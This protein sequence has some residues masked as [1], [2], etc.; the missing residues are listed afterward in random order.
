MKQSPFLICIAAILLL[1]AC[2]PIAQKT[3]GKRYKGKFE[4]AGLCSNYTF[5]NTDGTIDESLVVPLWTNPQTGKIY[6]SAFTVKNPCDLPK[7]LK[8]GDEFY[9]EITNGPEKNCAVCLALYPTPEKKLNIKVLERI[10]K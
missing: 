3:T 1:A 8:E 10:N 2:T 5:S 4:V 6:S 9:F 7:D